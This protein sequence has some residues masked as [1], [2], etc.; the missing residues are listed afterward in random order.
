MHDSVTG[1][2]ARKIKDG[3]AAEVKRQLELGVDDLLEEDRHLLDINL[4]DLESSTGERQQYWLLAIEAARIAAQ[5]A[6]VAAQQAGT[7]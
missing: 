2:L 5:L 6:H 4:D 1:T 7:T 3:L